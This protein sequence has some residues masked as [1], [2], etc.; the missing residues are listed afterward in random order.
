[1]FILVL[2]AWLT[3]RIENKQVFF[4][5]LKKFPALDEECVAFAVPVGAEFRRGPLRVYQKFVES[6]I[7][8]QKGVQKRVEKWGTLAPWLFFL[9]FP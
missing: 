5:L 6:H 3:R 1:L 2:A 9:S 7:S 4:R 8:G